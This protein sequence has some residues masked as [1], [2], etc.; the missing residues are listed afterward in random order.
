MKTIKSLG[1]KLG[2]K[3]R[4]GLTPTQGPWY[5]KRFKV[6]SDLVQEFF[7]ARR[8]P[9]QPYATSNCYLKLADKKALMNYPLI[10]R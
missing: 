6:Q 1:I 10:N 5:Q 8:I 7:F 4:Y 2:T 3:L 9:S